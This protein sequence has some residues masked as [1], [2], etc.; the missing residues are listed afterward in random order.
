MFSKE[1]WML[2]LFKFKI[3]GQS[4]VIAFFFLQF[5]NVLTKLLKLCTLCQYTWDIRTEVVAGK[6]VLYSMHSHLNSS[7]CSF[8]HHCPLAFIDTK[9][10]E[11]FIS[12]SPLS[13][14]RIKLLLQA[15]ETYTEAPRVWYARHSTIHTHRVTDWDMIPLRPL[16]LRQGLEPLCAHFL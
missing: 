8:K 6:R 11:Q 14:H 7:S 1:E 15:K 3:S 4:R 2:L 16:E 13:S 5:S 10:C 9:L 12:L